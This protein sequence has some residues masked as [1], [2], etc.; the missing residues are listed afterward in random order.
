MSD[1]TWNCSAFCTGSPTSLLCKTLSHAEE[2]AKSMKL[3]PMLV[4]CQNRHEPFVI[5]PLSVLY[6]LMTSRFPYPFTENF[7]HQIAPGYVMLSFERLLNNFD[8]DK[9][10][11]RTEYVRGTRKRRMASRRSGPEFGCGNTCGP[12]GRSYDYHC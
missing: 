12:G 3:I 2:Q 11:G 5:M 1:K 4:V 8:A 6:S 7:I 10:M 9:F